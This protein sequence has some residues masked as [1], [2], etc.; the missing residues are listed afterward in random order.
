MDDLDAAIVAALIT[1]HA[2]T[3]VTTT[4]QVK[5]EK[6]KRPTVSSAGGHISLPDGMIMSTLQRSKTKNS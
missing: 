1:T 6:V 5:E 4:V 3:H 2:K